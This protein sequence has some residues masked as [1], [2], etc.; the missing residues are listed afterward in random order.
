MTVK[1]L[2]LVKYAGE[3]FCTL[4]DYTETR[5]TEGYSD[6]A[7]VKSAVRTFVVKSDATKYISFRGEA[8]LKNIIQ[9]N[10][11]NP[12]FHE[13]DFRGTRMG[14]IAW[15]MLEPLNN[16]FKENKEYKKAFAQFMKE[17]NDYIEGQQS[18]ESS[19][20]NETNDPTESRAIVIRTLRSELNRVDKEIE[21]RQINREKI[22]QAINALESLEVE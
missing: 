3:Y 10:K 4:A 15:D 17:A 13:E 1:Q 9:E 7:S 18:K 12:H 5:S 8:Q 6:S 22:L 16:R 11:D 21:V 19:D 2:S 14:I 20:A